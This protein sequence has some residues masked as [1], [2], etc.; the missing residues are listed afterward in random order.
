MRYV[1]IGDSFTEGVGDE[2]AAGVPRGWADR[3]AAGLA[4]ASGEP[5]HYANLAVRGRL[6]A[7]VVGPQLDAALALDPAPTL[8]TLNGGG[9]DM[10]RPPHRRRGARRAHHPRRRPLRGGRGPAGAAQRCRPVGPASTGTGRPPP[11]RGAVGGGA[12]AR[13]HTRTHLRRRV[14]RR[15]DPPARLLVGRPPAPGHAR[16]SARRGNR[17]GGA[18]CA[19]GDARDDRRR[20]PA[21]RT[22]RSARL[23]P[24]PR[25][26]LGRT[27]SAGPVVRGRPAGEGSVLDGRPGAL[28]CADP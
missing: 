28:S 25:P 4:G 7:D 14:R 5:V 26:A 23:L 17:A 3:V 1:A 9:N 27:T 13:R 16:A 6:L 19:W 11:R 2:D 10:L 22:G 18:R 21:D 15:R 24:H 20:G 12:H 8:I